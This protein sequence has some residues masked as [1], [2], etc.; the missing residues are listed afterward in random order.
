MLTPNLII[1]FV[2]SGS[3]ATHLSNALHKAGYLVPQI[4]SNNIEEAKEL[5][6]KIGIATCTNN[7]G[8]L[9]PCDVVILAV[10]DS[11][12]EIVSKELSEILSKKYF[13]PIV[14]HCSGGTS[15]NALDSNSRKG[16]FWPL[17]TFTKV[18][19]VYFDDV[20]IFIEGDTECV[21]ILKLMGQSICKEIHEIDS[22]KRLILHTGA[23]YASN[24]TNYM[25]TIAD[26][27]A[28]KAGFDYNIYMPLFNEVVE[29]LEYLHPID[30]QTGP[31][32]RHDLNTV[33]LQLELMEKF[34]PQYS[35]LYKE[36]SQLIDAKYQL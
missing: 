7:L 20:P 23:V 24:F 19:E 35:F 22:E 15:I 9:L 4:I 8:E 10:P 26:Q 33:K 28:S 16:V 25:L 11:Q 21:A 1:N 36:L 14:V 13:N 30:A 34:F 27:I 5:A 12:I 2:G 32:K 6:D 18:K 31:S 17:Q 29:K 3:I